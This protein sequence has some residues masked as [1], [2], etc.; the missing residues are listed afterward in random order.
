MTGGDGEKRYSVF[1]PNI[2]NGKYNW[3]DREHMSSA[4]HRAKAVKN[5]EKYLRPLTLPQT[6]RLVHSEFKHK[7]NTASQNMGTELRALANELRTG[8]FERGSFR[9]NAP[10]ALQNELNNIL[11]SDY[12][13]VDKELEQTLHKTFAAREEYEEGRK[14]TDVNHTFIEAYQMGGRQCFRGRDNVKNYSS[15][16]R[17]DEMLRY[18]QEDL[19]EHLMGAIS[20]LSMVDAGQYVV[21]VGYRAGSNMFYVKCE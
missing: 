11:Q 14:L 8:F 16:P 21:G 9:T 20:V 6:M 12:V 17:D 13:F 10:N 2:T 19:P 18:T 7:L 1:S 3:G 5:A 4:L 15:V